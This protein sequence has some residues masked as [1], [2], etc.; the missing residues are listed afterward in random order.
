[1][2]TI[3]L[4][5]EEIVPDYDLEKGIIWTDWIIEHDGWLFVQLHGETWGAQTGYAPTFLQAA[6]NY[7]SIA[8]VDLTSMDIWAKEIQIEGD[9]SCILPCQRGDVLR[10]YAHHRTATDSTTHDR[11]NPHHTGNRVWMRIWGYRD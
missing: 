10:L 9:D 1:M 3:D 4:A 7:H 11:V 6:L 8:T 2:Q 5:A